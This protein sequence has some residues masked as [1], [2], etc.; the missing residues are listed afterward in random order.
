M[1]RRKKRAGSHKW[2]SLIVM[3]DKI[4]TYSSPR[5]I[6]CW[7]IRGSSIGCTSSLFIFPIKKKKANKRKQMFTMYKTQKCFEHKDCCCSSDVWKLHFSLHSPRL[8]VCVC[9]R[10]HQRF[11]FF[12]TNKA[13]Y[14]YTLHVTWFLFV[15][16]STVHLILKAINK[17]SA[18]LLK[19][20]KIH[21]NHLNFT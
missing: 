15:Q 17:N 1:W 6:S 20:L 9:V 18:R 4:K 14:Y 21:T 12:Y 16:H 10:G 5:W 3:N 19:A 8:C 13:N 2:K 11:L 7:W